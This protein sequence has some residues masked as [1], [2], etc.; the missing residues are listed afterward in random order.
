MTTPYNNNIDKIAG[1]SCLKN[2]TY[3]Q[4]FSHNPIVLRIPP[5]T[6][7]FNAK[8]PQQVRANDIF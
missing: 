6:Q 5:A 2:C 1:H 8:N 3:A 4:A 7:F